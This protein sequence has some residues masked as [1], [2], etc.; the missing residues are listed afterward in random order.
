MSLFFFWVIF[1]FGLEAVERSSGTG[2]S[3]R[4]WPRGWWQHGP[5]PP[6]SL[7]FLLLH[8]LLLL[9]LLINLLLLLLLINL[10][11][12][13]LNWLVLV[14][15][16][17]HLFGFLVLVLL[18]DLLL[19][20]RLLLLLLLLLLLNWLVLVPLLLFGLFVLVLV[21]LLLLDLLLLL[22][23]LRLLLSLGLLVFVLLL[24]PLL[25]LPL[26]PLLLFFIFFFCLIFLLI[27]L[28]F[29]FFWFLF[30]DSCSCWDSS[31][32]SSGSSWILV[33]IDISP[34]PVSSF[35]SLFF[36]FRPSFYLSL[37]LS[38][39]RFPFRFLSRLLK[40]LVFDQLID[41]GHQSVFFSLWKLGTNKRNQIV[42]HSDS[43]WVK[44]EKNV[45][46][47]YS[48]K[49]DKQRRPIKKGK[50]TSFLLFF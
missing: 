36:P 41:H 18:L 46:R 37:S 28:F 7:R 13:L 34:L 47:S 21:V 32:C 49:R 4:Q 39:F 8:L 35:S 30:F 25:L 15:V 20:L 9:L 1:F 40:R 3:V 14:L 10:L 45:R 44:F 5:V 33:E 48:Q 29:L 16:P 6:I 23:L 22:R 42:Q 24:H 31:P 12:L 26:P 43:N 27:F 17:L 50:K 38:F 11:L 2:I 19:L